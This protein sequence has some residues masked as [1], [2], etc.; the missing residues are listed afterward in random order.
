MDKGKLIKI[1]GPAWL[2]MIADMDASSIIG[3][4]QTGAMFNYGFVWLLLLLIIPLYIVQEASARIGVV[5]RKGIGTMIRE[6]YGKKLAMLMAF[7]MALTDVVTYVAEFI[8]IAVGLEILGVPSYYGIPLAFVVYLAIVTRKSYKYIEIALLSISGILIFGLIATLLLRGIQPYSPFFFSSSPHY[9]FLLAANIG[10]VVMPF[11]IFFQA[12]ATAIKL[13]GEKSR[14]PKDAIL[15]QERRNTLIG[16]VVTELLMVVVEMTFAGSGA[17]NPAIFVYPKELSFVMTPIAGPFAEYIFGIGLLGAG[18]LALSVV[19]L[20]SAWGVAEAANIRNKKA[21]YIAESLP[22]AIA[23]ML[24]PQAELI[25][26]VLYLLVFF[27]FT[28]VGPVVMLGLIAQN[29][30][31]LGKYR[32]GKIGNIIYWLSAAILIFLATIAVAEVI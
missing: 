1:F 18:F 4:A 20:G 26:A 2:V 5:T 24:I 17:N 32:T 8:G 22:A 15:R 25:K 12:S 19:A 16:A 30:S 6:R 21:I 28:L 27:V 7:P 11:M 10:A 13:N 29:K 14:K 23:S 31:I 3:A 9:L